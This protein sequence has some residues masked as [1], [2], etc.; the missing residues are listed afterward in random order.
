MSSAVVEKLDAIKKRAGMNS[1]EVAQLIET[2][3]QTVSRWRTGTTSPRPGS[4]DRLLRL[5][6]I[7]DELAQFYEPDQARLWIFSPHRQLGGRRPADLIAEDRTDDVLRLI[8]QLKSAA[9]I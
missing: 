3:P 8:D 5:E 4:L 6:W 7:A 1:R 9:Y 2:T